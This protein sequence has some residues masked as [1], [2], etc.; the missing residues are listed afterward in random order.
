MEKTITKIKVITQPDPFSLQ[1]CVNIFMEDLDVK[2]VQFMFD[3][4]TSEYLAIITYTTFQQ[5]K[6][7]KTIDI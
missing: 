6:L 4:K 1:S 3:I 7:K 5:N 2:N